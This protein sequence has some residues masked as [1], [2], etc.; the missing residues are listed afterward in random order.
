MFLGDDEDVSMDEQSEKQ[1]KIDPKELDPD[2]PDNY[3]KP[4][5]LY[6]PLD[7]PM[8]IQDYSEMY[9][10]G[11][12]SP[13]I[14]EPD[15][16]STSAQI[17]NIN[18]PEIQS[19]EVHSPEEVYSGQPEIDESLI[20]NY[21]KPLPDEQQYGKDMALSV[22]LEMEEKRRTEKKT[23]EITDQSRPEYEEWFHFLDEEKIYM[24]D[25]CD[26]TYGSQEEG[27]EH[28]RSVHKV[29]LGNDANDQE[30]QEE[31]DDLI[32][33][34]IFSVKSISRKYVILT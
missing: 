13:E 19:H 30:E 3:V 2:N 11:H 25:K 4:D 21:M 10:A 16:E 22:A 7:E 27:H 23:A 33:R 1:P 12:K 29:K 14:R 31:D 5:D 8:E 6:Q 26:T 15:G 17:S 28:L 32:F 34:Y 24:C 9:N 18:S 20:P